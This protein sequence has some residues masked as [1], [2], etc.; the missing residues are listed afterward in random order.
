MGP[1]RNP[2]WE[3]KR[4]E[5]YVIVSRDRRCMTCK[6]METAQKFQM[7]KNIPSFL[8]YQLQIQQGDLPFGMW[9]YVYVGSNT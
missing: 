7:G 4:T 3:Q 1:I 2:R 6:N 5:G 9:Y 8:Q